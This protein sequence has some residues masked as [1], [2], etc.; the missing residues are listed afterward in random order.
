MT[1]PRSIVTLAT[2]FVLAYCL[3]YYLTS[4]IGG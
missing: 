1:G 4:P 3:A 2:L